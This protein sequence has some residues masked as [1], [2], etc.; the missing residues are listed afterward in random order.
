MKKDEKIL[1]LINFLDFD[2][3]DYDRFEQSD[4]NPNIY[5]IDKDKEI[6]SCYKNNEFLVCT[7]EEAEK[8]YEDSF[9][10]LIDDLGLE[11]FSKEAQEYILENCVIDDRAT[12][13]DEAFDEL[14]KLIFC[15]IW[16]ERKDRKA[17]TP[18]DFQIITVSPDEEPNAEKRRQKENENL[19][20]RINELYEEGRK[21]DPEV[22]KDSISLNAE[23]IR[24][25]VGY[26]ESVSLSETDLDSKGR[27]FETFMGSYFRGEYGQ[28]FTPREVV[29]FIVDVLPIK[30]TSKVI[31]STCGSGGFLLYSLNKVREAASD[32]YPDYKT[33]VNQ[34][35]RW[36]NYWHD[37]ASNNLF[38]IEISGQISRAA[39]MNM[40]LH[41]DGHTNVITE[42]GLFSDEELFEKTGNKGFG[43]GTFDFVITNPPFG[44]KIKQTEKA[45]LKEYNFGKKPED[46]LELDTKPKPLRDS[47][48]TE[49][50]FIEQN[51]KFLKEGGFLS[52]VLPDGVLTNS[53]MQFV[54]TQIEDWFRIIA[55]ISLPQFA[56]RANKAGVKSSIL[57]LQKWSKKETEQILERKKKIQDALL[58]ETNYKETIK[59]WRKDLTKRENEF[60]DRIKV[61]QNISRTKAKQ[62]EEYKAWDSKEKE[63]LKFKIEM[64]QNQLEDKYL[65]RKQEILDDYQKVKCI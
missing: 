32:M 30:N 14:D 29:S 57:F 61:Q 8:E 46:W 27:A 1:A 44:S 26:L 11:S 15:K 45:Y 7:D 18:Y 19:R 17:G 37:F 48:S 40:I 23:K 28:Y 5:I 38:G 22:F 36:H 64:L 35:Q 10:S 55:V 21:K 51:Y 4:Y 63:K 65:Q 3:A 50:L 2:E 52:I 13:L 49:V 20:N 39:K 31:D 34:Y 16:D 54:R 41:D 53:S 42:D 24:T 9:M 56:F 12:I 33:D 60:A 58:A 59:L 43:Y 6:K 62:T 25:V 47:Q